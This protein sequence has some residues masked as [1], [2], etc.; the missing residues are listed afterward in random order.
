MESGRPFVWDGWSEFTPNIKPERKTD[1]I[2]DDME[3]W[4]GGTGGNM[5]LRDRN[6]RRTFENV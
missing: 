5:V 3:M 1:V 2:C 4:T 6:V